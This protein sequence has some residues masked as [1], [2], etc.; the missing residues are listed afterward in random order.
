MM[1]DF[2]VDVLEV[3]QLLF[4]INFQ[5]YFDQFEEILKLYLLIESMMNM[6]LNLN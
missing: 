3:N 6:K 5:F 4:E 1:V 2:F